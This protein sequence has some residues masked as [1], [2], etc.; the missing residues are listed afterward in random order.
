MNLMVVGC[1]HIVAGAQRDITEC[2]MGLKGKSREW[3][4]LQD[5]SNCIRCLASIMQQMGW[6]IAGLQHAHA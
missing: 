5:K 3:N 2:S 4:N 1:V 6:H